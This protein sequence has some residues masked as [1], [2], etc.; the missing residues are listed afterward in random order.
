MKHLLSPEGAQALA[1]VLER[2]PL[3]AFDFD[4]TLAP[5]VEQPDDARVPDPVVRLL[6][7]LAERHPIAVITGRDVA[8]VR[9]RLGF[10]PRWVVGNH[11]AESADLGAADAAAAIDALNVFRGQLAAAAPALAAAGVEVEDKR[12]SIA[13]HDRRAVDEARA[14]ACIAALLADLPA[15][16]HAFGGKRVTNVAARALPDKGDALHALVRRAGAGAAFFA[17]DDV[18][19]EAVFVCAEP[20][21]LTVRIGRDDP[22]SRAMYGLDDPGELVPVLTLM[23]DS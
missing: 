14:R 20:H 13:L 23:L 15:A 18:N 11:G 10:E 12:Y 19:D 4:G 17:G 22:H 3:V 8:D 2:T 21:W 16:L 1:A 6:Q 7:R 9:A 5:I